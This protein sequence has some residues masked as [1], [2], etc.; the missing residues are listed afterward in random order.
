[1]DGANAGRGSTADDD[2]MIDSTLAHYRI[3]GELGSGGMGEVWRAED[4]KLG[5][6]VAL[7]VMPADVAQ[8][9]ERLAR[10]ER[11][12]KVLAS[13]NHPNIAHLYGLETVESTVGE[14]MILSRDGA[15]SGAGGG[16][17]AV[18]GPQAQAPEAPATPSGPVTF[19]VMELVEGEDLSD[20]ITRGP[21]PVD[22]TARIALQIAE[23]VEA[24]HESGIVHRDLKPANI[25]LRP[26]GTV[27]V[28]DFGL[29][30]AWEAENS[31]ASLSLS[32]TMTQHATAAGVILGTAAY[33]SPEQAAGTEA[34]RRADI[35]AFG[36]VLWEMF[37]GHKLF[38]GETVS[39]VLASVLKDDVD[40][41]ELPDSTPARLQRLVG[42]CLERQPRKR[43]QAMG[44]ARIALEEY[45]RD[46]EAFAESAPVSGEI[47]S[48]RSGVGSTIP[49]AIAVVATLLLA[50]SAWLGLRPSESERKVLRARIPAP[51]GASFGLEAFAPGA[52]TI[53]P[54]GSRIVFTVTDANGE[55][56]LWVRHIDHLTARP[57][58]ATNGAAYPFWAPDSRQ[59]AYFS[60]DGKLRK[61][62]TTGGPPVTICVAPNGKGGS[63]NEE[64]K[65]VFAPAHNT[66]IHVVAAAGGE[67]RA[68]TEVP[69][70]V[71]SHRFPMWLPGGRFTYLARSA[72][73]AENDRVMVAS[74]DELGADRELLAAGSNVAV[75]AATCSSSARE[76]SWHNLSTPSARP[77]LV[78][79]SRSRRMPSTSPARAM[80][81]SRSLRPASSSTTWGWS[82]C[83][84]KSCG[85]TGQVR[86]SKRSAPATSSS[87]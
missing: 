32:P 26:D 33:M 66:P 67:A 69:K 79:R 22:E 8:D 2:P 68:V 23:A 81:L 83:R 14:G 29:A 37:T 77:L 54:D 35:W 50:G 28:L 1:M 31:D 78:T 17:G 15:E 47:E 16:A 43:L 12:A 84:A 75:A 62:D 55:R 73:G 4:T 18:P 40:L 21:I 44:E 10:F 36:V 53:S 70:G 82:T 13:L 5:R 63:W 56:M 86:R 6:E 27:K 80:E 46:P 52:G 65:I 72:E 60:G 7:K 59:V 9:S 49:W 39:H 3:T 58:P 11:E 41:D 38:E 20:R 42:R 64:D 85:S 71:S 34:D 87:T 24:A 45:E 74:V 57:L 51:E 76:R 30:K 61:I 25:K 48:S 19:L